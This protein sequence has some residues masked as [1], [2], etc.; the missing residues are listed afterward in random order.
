MNSMIDKKVTI[1]VW[2]VV[3]LFIMVCG[4]GIY[5]VVNANKN[6]NLDELTA[7]RINVVDEGGN[8]R[9]VISNESRQ[10][11]GIVDGVE[12]DLRGRQPGMIFFNSSGDECGGLVYDG[13][14]NGAGLVLS[15][16]QFKNDQVM[17]LQYAEDTQSKRRK[18][19][20]QL[21]DYPS[22]HTFSQKY[23]RMNALSEIKD[24]EKFRK[25]YEALRSEGLIAEDRLFAGK[26]FNKEVGLFIRD[27]KGNLR[28]RIYID[29]N[30]NPKIEMLD[31]DGTPIRL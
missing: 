2:C 24:D 15:V 27:S 7:K 16:D 9:M 22:E 18:Y 6:L 17:Q 3:F 5:I 11:S 23:D 13:N 1:L 29:E 19:G 25:A 14:E 20:L 8:L 4:L 10:H 12:L 21:W 30:D 26:N 28:I 31:K